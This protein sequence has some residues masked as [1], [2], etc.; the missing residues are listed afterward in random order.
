MLYSLLIRL[1]M[2]ALTI[3]TVLWIG[4]SMPTSGYIEAGHASES[5]RPQ[6]DDAPST[7]TAIMSGEASSVLSEPAE[8][9]SPKPLPRALDLNRATERDLE[10]LPGIGLVLAQRIVQYRQAHGVFRDVAQLR[11]VKGIGQ[12]TFDRIRRLV[13]VARS[14]ATPAGKAA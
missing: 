1:A 6:T 5:S 9:F 3:G 12:K 14:A 10:G 8:A 7:G 11:R 13:G 2:L 4:W